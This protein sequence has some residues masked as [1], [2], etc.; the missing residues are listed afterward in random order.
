MLDA[1][2]HS[3]VPLTD[4]ATKKGHRIFGAAILRK[5]DL[6]VVCAGTNEGGD[7]CLWHGEVAAIRNYY[8]LPQEQRVPA[9][10]CFFVATHEPC[11]L[12]L[13]AITWA[14][15]DNIFYLHTYEDSAVDFN[16]PMDLQMLDEVFGCKAGAYRRQNKFWT[17]YALE[18]LTAGFED[19]E[20]KRGLQQH[21]AALRK[22]YVR[23]Q[24][25]AEANA[26][27]SIVL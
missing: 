21:M 11:P 19:G 5:S 24:A 18:A 15:Y 2:Q 12:C 6:S 7:C 8:R 14:G 9:K 27:G 23:L 13:S 1:I 4:Q 26:T 16:M 20:A 10:D 17:A 25:Q 22:E 3:V